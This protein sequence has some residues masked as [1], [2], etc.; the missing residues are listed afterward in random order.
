[1]NAL[2]ITIIIILFILFCPIPIILKANINEDGGSLTLYKKT[3]NF[4][5]SKISTITNGTFE[6]KPTKKPKKKKKK[7]KIKIDVLKL[8]SSINSIKFKP[9]FRMKLNIQYGFEDAMITGI[10]YGFI[11]SIL[12]FLKWIIDIPFKSKKYDFKIAPIFDKNILLLF[13]DCIIW[14]NIAKIL[15]IMIIIIKNTKISK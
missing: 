13:L 1:M 8:I 2:L 11:G 14:L 9:T 4:P 6:K 3:F 7:S 15:Y 5:S 12:Y 10:S